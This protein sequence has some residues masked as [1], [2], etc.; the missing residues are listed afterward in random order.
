MLKLFIR[1][2]SQSTHK[3]LSIKIY[4]FTN[5]YKSSNKNLFLQNLPMN[6]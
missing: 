4:T 1:P 3:I 6:R 2:K 5:F